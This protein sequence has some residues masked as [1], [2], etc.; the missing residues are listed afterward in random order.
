MAAPQAADIAASPE[1]TTPRAGTAQPGITPQLAAA[2]STPDAKSTLHVA[3]KP[4]TL[5]SITVKIAHDSA[6]NA[7]V[8]ITASQPDT[9]AALKKDADTLGQILAGAGVPEANRQVTFQAAQAAAQPGGAPSMQGSGFQP[10]SQNNAGFAGSF[11]SSFANPN[12]Q[13]GGHDTGYTPA[14]PAS[15]N[16]L[17]ADPGLPASSPAGAVRGTGTSTVNVF[18]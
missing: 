9:L 7:N 4:E 10:S 18:A 1:A 2:F 8:T 16:A 14:R 5:G 3:L 11:T 12:S 17:S 6:G 13:G 15:G